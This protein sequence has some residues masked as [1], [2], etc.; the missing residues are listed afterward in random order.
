M[1]WCPSQTLPFYFCTFCD[2]QL[3]HVG[4]Y[5]SLHPYL[6]YNKTNNNTVESGHKNDDDAVESKRKSNADTVESESYNRPL[7]FHSV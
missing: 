7:I 5:A 4:E 1:I 2:N 6:N 3:K